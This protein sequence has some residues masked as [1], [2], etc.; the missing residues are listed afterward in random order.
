MIVDYLCKIGWLIFLVVNK[1]EGMKYMVVVIDFYEF[2]FGD[3]CV[4]LVVYGDGVIDMIN[5]VFEVVYVG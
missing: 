2:G 3:L 1:V 5:E 4:I